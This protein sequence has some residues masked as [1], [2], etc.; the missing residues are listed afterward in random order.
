MSAERW[1]RTTDSAD[2][3]RLRLAIQRL[4]DADLLTELQAD[5]LLAE[6]EAAS[7]LSQQGDRQSAKS[8]VERIALFTQALVKTNVLPFVDGNVVIRAADEV[9]GQDDDTCSSPITSLG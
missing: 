9:L 3:N 1:P 8:R 5:T 2:L 6:A 4:L 7:S